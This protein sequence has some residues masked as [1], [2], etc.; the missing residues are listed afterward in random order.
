MASARGAGGGSTGAAWLR[1]IKGL[2]GGKERSVIHLRASITGGAKVWAI[3][4]F[5]GCKSGSF[6][7]DTGAPAEV[8]CEY[9]YEYSCAPG[10]ERDF[11]IHVVADARPAAI[12][13]AVIGIAAA[14]AVVAVTAATAAA[15]AL[16]AVAPVEEG[17][18]AR[19]GA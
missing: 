13:A 14:T 3:W 2:S 16:A 6:A 18:L 17:Q 4:G 8:G 5:S 15:A 10:S 12:A 7:G 19:I 9:S 1:L 11:I